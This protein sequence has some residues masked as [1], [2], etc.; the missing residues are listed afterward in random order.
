LGSLSQLIAP[1]RPNTQVQHASLELI[2]DA[3]APWDPR[4]AVV[5]TWNMACSVALRDFLS[6][7]TIAA[8]QEPWRRALGAPPI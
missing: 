7:A 1:T 3:V 2:N 5:A 8:L 6:A 4:L